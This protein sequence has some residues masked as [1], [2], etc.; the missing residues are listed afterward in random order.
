MA[1]DA[2]LLTESTS[3]HVWGTAPDFVGPRHELRERLLLDLFLAA[4]PERRVLNVGAGQ[5]SFTRLLEARGFEVVS[6]DVTEPALAVLR[7]RVQGDVV[8]ADMTALAF[9]DASFDAVVAGEVLEHIEDDR[10]AVAEAARV[11]R[12]G[13]VLAV[14]VPAHPEWF[15]PSDAWAGHVRRYQRAALEDLVASR[16]DL[17]LVAIRPWGF[18]VS[19]LYHRFYYDKRADA[20]ASDET[21]P[22][23]A[24]AVL[25][26][27]LQVDR[28]FV[29]VELGCLGY[30]A[31]AR[32]A[33]SALD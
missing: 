12:P 23:R 32:S 24:V 28:L 19:A 22:G 11:L 25:R 16:P 27:A 3:E 1:R 33:A 26:A 18:P 8:R 31:V 21:R 17:E 6:T 14:S 2:R 13:G 10:Q 20:L 30:L 9:A 4:N 5:G 29:G 15:G 7:T